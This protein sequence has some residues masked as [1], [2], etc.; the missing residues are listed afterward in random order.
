MSKRETAIPKLAFAP[1][2]AERWPDLERLFGPRGG[3]GGCWCMTWRLRKAEYERGK[4]AGNRAAFHRIVRAG[5]PPGILGYVD[6]EAIAW[7]AVAPRTAYVQL[8]R[9]RVLKPID[10]QPVW[11]VSCLFVA[12]AHRR[13]GVSVAMLRAAGEFAASQGARIVE[14]YPVEPQSDKMPD[15]F[16]WTGTAAA[17]RTAGYDEVARGSPTRPI[18]RLHTAIAKAL[19]T[20]S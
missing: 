6:G 19:K 2:T 13:R 8:E 9:S 5:P 12:R 1:L 4:G 17:F 10:D 11:S 7:C 20:H 3:C 14:G 16:A 15:V 18:M